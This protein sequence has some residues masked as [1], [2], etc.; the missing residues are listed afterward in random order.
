MKMIGMGHIAVNTGNFQESLKF[1]RDILG[2]EE[3][4]TTNWGDFD[5]TMLGMPDGG[6]IEL[7]DYGLRADRAQSDN[8][9]VGYR[10]FALLVEDVD[11]WEAKLKENGIEISMAPVEMPVLGI[12][13][14]MCLDPDGVEVEL[15]EPL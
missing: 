10:H 7:F 6:A 11:G 14:L 13:G 8:S 15:Y 1:Y 3:I 12:K 2:F 9:V 4:S 5:M